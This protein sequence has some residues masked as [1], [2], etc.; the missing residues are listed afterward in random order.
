MDRIIQFNPIVNRLIQILS[1][2]RFVR[3]GRTGTGFA[4]KL[5]QI[6]ISYQVLSDT[7]TKTHIQEIDLHGSK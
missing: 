7:Q 5:P 1:W 4:R 6:S 3:N 2:A